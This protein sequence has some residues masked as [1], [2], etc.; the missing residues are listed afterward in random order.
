MLIAKGHSY[1]LVQ[2]NLQHKKLAMQELIQESVKRNFSFAL[3]QEPYV[4][5]EGEIKHHP[6]IR[7]IQKLRDRR[8]PVKAAIFVFDDKLRLYEDCA[9]TTENIAVL[10]LK[11]PNCTLALVSVYFEVNQPLTPYLDHV[12]KIHDKYSSNY[13]LIG[14]DVNAWSTWWGSRQE[15]HR[16]A[17]LAVFLEELDLQILNEGDEPTFETI[18]GGK[19]YMSRVDITA[20]PATETENCK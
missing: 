18:R 2:A 11:T 15:N 10:T 3:V 7:T 1:K 5:A 12:K 4:G 14:G 8:G 17:E 20:R 13:L 6:G 19:L 9:L 16:G